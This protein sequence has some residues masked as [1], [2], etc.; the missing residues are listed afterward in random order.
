MFKIFKRFYQFLFQYKKALAAFGIVLVVA[1]ILENLN[2]YFYKL[3][4]DRIPDRHYW[5]LVKILIL[6]VSVRIA[7]NLLN[8]LSHYLGDKVLLPAARRYMASA[9]NPPRAP[10][11]R[12]GRARRGL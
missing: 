10:R 3:L 12:A 9:D 2:P 11:R 6:F 7:A 4:I 5:N 8:S 1:S